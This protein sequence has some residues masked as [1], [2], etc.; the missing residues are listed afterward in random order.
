[1]RQSSFA[2]EWA[3]YRDFAWTGLQG[4]RE[5]VSSIQGTEQEAASESE[6][7]LENHDNQP[8]LIEEVKI[9]LNTDQK[10]KTQADT[11]TQ[12]LIHLI[13]FDLLSL[14]GARVSSELNGSNVDT[15]S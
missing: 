11:Q 12:E 15:V 3:V 5:F 1:M 14:I 9:S 13:S 7:L 2:R 10:S 4:A 8:V 6:N